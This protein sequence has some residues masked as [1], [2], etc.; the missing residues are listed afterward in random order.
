VLLDT[1]TAAPS[2]TWTE[3]LTIQVTIIRLNPMT[4]VRTRIGLLAV[5]IVPP[6]H[7]A[8]AARPSRHSLPAQ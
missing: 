7:L 6:P 2:P 8:T 5:F 4:E 1:E 3:K